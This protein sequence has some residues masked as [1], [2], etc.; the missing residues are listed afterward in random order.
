MRKF[1]IVRNGV[2]SSEFNQ[3]KFKS[4]KF[5]RKKFG[6]E[7]RTTILTIGKHVKQKGTEYLIKSL[8][9]L[10]EKVNLV[11]PSEGPRTKY[12]KKIA[13]EIDKETGSKTYFLGKVTNREIRELLALCDIFVL[14]SLNEGLPLTL[15]EAMSF[16]KAIITTNVGGISE[17]MDSKTGILVEPRN[18]SQIS[19]GINKIISNKKFRDSIEGNSRKYVEKNLDWKKIT[20]EYLRIY[21]ECLK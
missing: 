14:P 2:D 9:H 10:N 1:R 7:D 12:L 21:K 5:Y 19:N 13:K 18:E 11:I 6:F 15:L 20:D 16:G 4:K 8:K 3:K 17:I